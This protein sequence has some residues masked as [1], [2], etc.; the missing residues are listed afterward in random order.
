MG[1]SQTLKKSQAFALDPSPAPTPALIHVLKPC[2]QFSPLSS[3]N[4]IA[5]IWYLLRFRDVR[6]TAYPTGSSGIL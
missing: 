2:S 4:N 6:N 3:E 5:H 1:R